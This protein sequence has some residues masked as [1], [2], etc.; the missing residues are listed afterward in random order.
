MLFGHDRKV[1]LTSGAGVK[2]DIAFFFCHHHDHLDSYMVLCW[3]GASFRIGGKIF[4][5][6]YYKE[7][8]K[9]KY[10]NQLPFLFINIFNYTIA[11]YL[12]QILQSR[13][14]NN[15]SKL[16]SLSGHA[17]VLC[18]KRKWYIMKKICFF[19]DSPFSA[20][21]FNTPLHLSESSTR[22]RCFNYS[23]GNWVHSWYIQD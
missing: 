20:A 16:F 6:F 8:L 11:S 14:E 7:N 2:R 5:I 10:S 12:P 13:L 17:S 18:F 22:I 9:I 23:L 21:K 3:L 1:T 4:F 19:M 15:V